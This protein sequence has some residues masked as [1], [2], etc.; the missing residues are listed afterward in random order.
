MQCAFQPTLF[1]PAPGIGRRL[2]FRGRMGILQAMRHFKNGIPLHAEFDELLHLPPG[3]MPR[4]LT[5][6]AG[7]GLIHTGTFLAYPGKG[8]TFPGLF[9]YK[10]PRTGLWFCLD[11]NFCR[12]RSGIAVIVEGDFT[13]HHNGK[14]TQIV[15]HSK[16]AVLEAFPQF[17]GWYRYHLCRRLPVLK[18]GME[19]ETGFHPG[20]FLQCIEGPWLGALAR[21]INSGNSDENYVHAYG[22][23]S[24]DR[25][26]FVWEYYPTDTQPKTTN[27]RIIIM[28]G[29][30]NSPIVTPSQQ[31]SLIQGLP[32]EYQKAKKRW[33][34]DMILHGMD[35]AHCPHPG[36][37]P[38]PEQYLPSPKAGRA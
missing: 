14:K 33:D 2:G 17:P 10:D 37:P 29:A 22:G 18:D 32:R 8:R 19:D 3:K 4:S 28:P 36:P 15:P 34:Q 31:P 16:P 35:P 11:T 1:H 30:S 6:N 9:E 38:K 23:P 21:T 25:A 7:V 13:L 26:V 24:L 5:S 27:R 12:G 20:R